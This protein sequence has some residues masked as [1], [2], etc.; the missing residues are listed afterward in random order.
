MSALADVFG[1]TYPM[2]QSFKLVERCRSN[3]GGDHD[4]GGGGVTRNAND[5]RNRRRRR[6]RKRD[7][8]DDDTDDDDTD[9]DDDN[10]GGGV[11]SGDDVGVGGVE[12]RMARLTVEDAAAVEQWLAYW[13]IYGI[14]LFVV[15][16]FCD[17]LLFWVPFYHVR[18]ATVL[19]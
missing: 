8:D 1:I 16:V 12:R 6:R 9:D 19:L 2:Y 17:R 18:S 14:V 10:G 3:D 15:D 4:N 5:G 7:D 13:V 11:V